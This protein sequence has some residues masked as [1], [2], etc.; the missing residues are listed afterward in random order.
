MTL[1]EV[2]YRIEALKWYPVHIRWLQ[3]KIAEKEKQIQSAKKCGDD[4]IVN[5]IEL[6]L[7]FYRERLQQIISAQETGLNFL[8]QYADNET[9]YEILIMHFA[10]GKTYMQVADQLYYSERTINMKVSKAI[11]VLTE[12]AKDVESFPY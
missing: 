8:R 4:Y 3:E 2:K 7:D 10:E 11:K 12:N 9:D 5:G 1:N 6:L